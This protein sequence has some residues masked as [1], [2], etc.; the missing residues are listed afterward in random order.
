MNKISINPHLS[1]YSVTDCV[2]SDL[3]CTKKLDLQPIVYT[4][5]NIGSVEVLNVIY[6]LENVGISLCAHRERRTLS[7]EIYC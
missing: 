3:E 5:R 7:I 2:L 6:G 1:L 4:H